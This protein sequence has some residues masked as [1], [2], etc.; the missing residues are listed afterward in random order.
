VITRREFLGTAAALAG[1]ACAARAP[2]GGPATAPSAT[3][4]GR[5]AELGF[6][7]LGCP[8]WS[9]EEVLSFATAHGFATLELRGLLADMDLTR[10]PE[11][12]PDRLE[13]TRRQLAER[14]LRV[15]CLGA[16]ASMHEMEPAKRAAAID[17]GRRFVDLAAALR[18]PYVR[19]FG[20]R[21]VTGV[22]RDEMLAHIARGL[23]ELGDHAHPRG[24]SVLVESHGDF[25]DSAS[26]REL[27]E[28]A[29]SP[30]VALLWDAHHTFVLGKEQP[31]QTVRAL[32]PWI[33]HTHLKDSVPAGTDRRYVLTGTG[34][35]PVRRQVQAL[36]ASGY[37]G[38]YSFEWEKRWHPDIEEPE[39]A[40]AHYARAVRQYLRV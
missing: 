11:F 40:I 33:R 6:S 23:R 19:V 14:H 30:G 34:E 18:A 32:G 25:T 39:V 36:V 7:T 10:R 5:A 21:Y 13:A 26:L 38:A 20:D 12:A 28:R 3:D 17:E 15:T 1:A 22:P 27:L 37:T 9:W 2:A 4:G 31:E 24:V 29:N 35:V 8:K 16:S